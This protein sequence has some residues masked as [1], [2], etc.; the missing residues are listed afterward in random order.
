M[1]DKHFVGAD[2]VSLAD[3][4]KYKPVSRVTL[5]LDDNNCL[6]A[7][8]DTGY[9]LVAD[10]PHATQS[11]LNDLLASLKGHEHK[12]FE[13]GEVNIDPASELGDGVTVCGLYAPICKFKDDGMGYPSISSPGKE[14]LEDEYPSVGPIEKKFNRD[15]AKAYSIISKTA[16]EIL[17]E[18]GETI[19]DLGKDESGK[20]YTVSSKI[21]QT[22]ESI[23]HEVNGYF[24]QDRYGNPI[25]VSSSIETALEGITM[26]A[27]SSQGKTTLTLTSSGGVQ[28]ASQS[29]GNL[30]QDDLGRNGTTTIYGGLIETDSVLADSL[31]LTGILSVYSGEFRYGQELVGGYLGYD[32]GFNGTK[33]IGIRSSEEL[34]QVVC[35]DTAARISYGYLYEISQVVCSANSVLIAGNRLIQMAT[36]GITRLNVDSDG[37]YP[38]GLNYTCGTSDLPWKDIYAAGTSM[39]ELLRRIEVLENAQGG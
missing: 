39:S 27:S 5:Y 22:A 24:D 30:T 25:P 26:S 6:T 13:A 31:H 36:G 33:G 14:E 23:V 1:S 35:T 3:N 15:I 38:S 2:V 29:F 8:D 34:S 28:I 18:V 16:E 12:S 17:L 9:E 7:G 4:G 21:K 20:P 10:C 11:M 37:I 19:G 32:E